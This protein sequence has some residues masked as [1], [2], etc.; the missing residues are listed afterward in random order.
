MLILSY[1]AANAIYMR[2]SHPEFFVQQT[3]GDVPPFAIA[4]AGFLSRNERLQWAVGT[5]ILIISVA[6]AITFND[7][8]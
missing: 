8:F 7:S 3:L 4:L 1:A 2:T 6:W 5:L